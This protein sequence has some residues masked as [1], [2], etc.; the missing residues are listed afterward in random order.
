[1]LL[2]YGREIDSEWFAM[3]IGA[4]SGGTPKAVDRQW[5][6]EFPHLERPLVLDDMNRATAAHGV[7]LM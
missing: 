4:V 1:M 2:C 5:Q 6:I 7:Y 3:T